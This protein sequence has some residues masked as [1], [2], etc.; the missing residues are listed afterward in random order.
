M[1]EK[2]D[3]RKHNSNNGNNKK[4]NSINNES[5]GM[6]VGNELIYQKYPKRKNV[7]IGMIVIRLTSKSGIVS[8]N[9]MKKIIKIKSMEN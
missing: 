9:L 5:N 4:R 3:K 7:L 2:T 8:T 6:N 1:R